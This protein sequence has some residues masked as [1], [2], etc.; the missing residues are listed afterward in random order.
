MADVHTFHLS[1]L[2]SHPVHVCL[3][4]GV[5]NTPFLRQQLLAG[6][7]EFEYAFVDATTVRDHFHTASGLMG[8]S[9]TPETTVSSIVFTSPASTTAL[10]ENPH[11]K[12]A[13]ARPDS[14]AK[15]L[16]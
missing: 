5:E 1:H 15:T 9:A 4:K 2:P 7:S 6:N 12:S 14:A 11:V 10:G 3:F 13:V 16:S 8:E